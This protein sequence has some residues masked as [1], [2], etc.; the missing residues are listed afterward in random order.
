MQELL[1]IRR[2]LK[3]MEEYSDVYMA[4]D[5]TPDQQKNHNEL[6]KKLREKIQTT[7]DKRFYIKN[8]EVLCDE[9]AKKVSGSSSCYMFD[10][11]NDNVLKD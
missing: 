10:T 8:G 5:R 6:V 11:I 2:D 1:R 3:K 7:P 4:P 9:D